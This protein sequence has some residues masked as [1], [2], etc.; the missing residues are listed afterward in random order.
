MGIDLKKLENKPP[1]KV[2]KKNH[3]LIAG[4]IA[5][6][7]IALASYNFYSNQQYNAAMAR[8]EQSLSN[9]DFGAA[10]ASYQAAEKYK[11]TSDVQDKVKKCDTLQDSFN[12]FNRA[13]D[14][15][16]KKDYLTAFNA[17]NKVVSQD[18]KRYQTAH[19][20]AVESS[21]L[22]S[23]GELA[24]AK[25]LATQADYPGALNHLDNILKI[26]SSN[27]SV[28][29]L[30]IDYKNKMISIEAEKKAKEEAAAKQKAIADA[31]SAITVA[32]LYTSAPNSA[33]GV[34][35]HI[36]WQNNSS[37]AIK[38]I[39]FTVTPYN[40]VGDPQKC[41]IRGYSS[42]RGKVTGPINPGATY[43]NGKQ[44]EVAWYNN[45]IVSAKLN[46]IDIT[47]MDDSTLSLDQT[48]VQ[49]LQ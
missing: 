33:S 30:E 43:G 31:R 37:K 22:Y 28:S 38:Y 24:A 42:F 7:I 2:L 49:Y 46:A 27:S 19:D 6:I 15:F 5:L 4:V 11:N 12:Q 48:Q 18:E 39:S 34:D 20:K 44:W 8:A 29:A 13:N 23:D 14:A 26:D 16:T 40:A 47:Y 9:D 35:L 21:K 10:K 32:S 45:T 25:D 41:E 17:Y 1:K 36:V 3:L